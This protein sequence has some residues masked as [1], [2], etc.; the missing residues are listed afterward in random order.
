MPR[1]AIIGANGQV[2]AELCLLLS[3]LPD[4][5]LV[6]VCRNH[7]GS[8]FLRYSGISCRHGLISEVAEAPSLI[9]DCD[10]IVNCA[11][12]TGTPRDIRAFDSRLLRNLFACSPR[13]AT[14]IHCSTLMVHGDP[15]P[16]KRLRYRSPYGR[17]KLAAEAMV[18]AESKRFGKA[19]FTV[20]LGHVCGPLQN[21]TANIRQEITNGQVLL[22]DID[23]ASN[24]VYTVTIVDA[25]LSILAGRESQGEFDLTNMPQWT[26]GEIYQYEALMLGA[27][28]DPRLVRL[29][30]SPTISGKLRHWLRARSS[31]LMHTA[32]VR[33][34][35]EKALALTP[36]ALND[37]AQ[38]TWFRA[39][40]RA[41]I[42]ALRP[43]S[44][45]APELSWIPLDRRHLSA[46][47][48]TRLL[49]ADDGYE[50]LTQ[51]PA[52]RWPNDLPLAS[53]L[54]TQADVSR[55]AAAGIS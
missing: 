32:A 54:Q 35:L 30:D 47:Q 26:W 42:E 9:G 19:A 55:G 29:A 34:T 1:V 8:A 46:L 6:P 16:G 51:D 49:L 39:R 52:V 7:S 33:Q 2:G 25:I 18:R 24:A 31:R 37:R 22:P 40:A 12:G 45:I 14:I 21:I 10:A 15:R 36:K 20:R 41:E 4:I 11:L 17:S 43:I 44:D 13:G 53:A 3:G 5:E 50:K 38:A 23:V 48:Q 27:R 28:L